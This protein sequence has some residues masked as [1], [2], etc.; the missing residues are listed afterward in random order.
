MWEAAVWAIIAIL[1]GIGGVFMTLTPPE[2]TAARICLLLA[3][4][5]LLCRFGYWMTVEHHFEN[6]ISMTIVAFALF[7]IIGAASIYGLRWVSDR[8]Y[9]FKMNAV[10]QPT[11][12]EIAKEVIKGLVPGL[13]PSKK[14]ESQPKESTTFKE[15]IENVAVSFG[16]GGITSGISLAQLQSGTVEPFNLG[17]YKPIKV[18]LDN[19]RLF[20]DVIVYGGPRQAPIE[21]KHNEFTI[22]VLG[23]DRNFDSSAL[24]VVNNVNFPVFQIIYQ[25]PSQIIIN[26]I[27]PSPAGLMLASE[28]GFMA[29]M[30]TIPKSFR[31]RRLF[32]YPSNQFP[33]QR[34]EVVR[35]VPAPLL[36]QRTMGL[37]TELLQFLTEREKVFRSGKSEEMRK[38]SEETWLIFDNK[39]AIKCSDIADELEASGL[40]VGRLSSACRCANNIISMK[41]IA[42]QLKL[43]ANQLP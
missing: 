11:A 41:E 18:Y 12:E 20:A 28:D 43:F 35:I 3:T 23:M 5:L 42:E 30:P 25:T 38:I 29:A 37:F 19:G 33:G 40:N 36:K 4:G 1:I 15:K 10:K 14:T 13:L 26:G 32:K 6:K 39:F 27:F 24:E 22:R 34:A 21:I 31:I 7:G 9:K 17:G 8:E 16:G 2:Y